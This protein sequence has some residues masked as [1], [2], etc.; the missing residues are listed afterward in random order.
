MSYRHKKSASR[1]GPKEI[2]GN[3]LRLGLISYDFFSTPEVEEEIVSTEKSIPIDT[4]N[5]LPEETEDIFDDSEEEE[6]VLPPS[7][8][9]ISELSDQYIP[10]Q[11]IEFEVEEIQE[12]CEKK[13]KRRNY[14][15]FRADYGKV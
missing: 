10:V 3:I 4:P 7:P 14:L 6:L 12:D 1:K 11:E 9:D 8:E 5:T 2:L 15:E 13:K